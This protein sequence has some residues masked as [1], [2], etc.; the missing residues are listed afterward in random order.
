MPRRIYRYDAGQGWELYNFLSSI[1]M[2]LQVIGTAIGFFNLWRSRRRGII[3]GNDPWGAPTLEWSIPSPP[4]DYNF[5]RVPTVRSRYPL[6][7]VKSPML[8]ADIPHSRGGERG[9]DVDVGGQHVGHVDRAIG[10]PPGAP[11]TSAAS[12]AA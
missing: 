7:D 1:G 3:A 11:R 6:W 4:P 2:Y 12:V 9:V 8:T 5:A 10:N